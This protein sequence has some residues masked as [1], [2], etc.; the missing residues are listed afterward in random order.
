MDADAHADWVAGFDA[1]FARVAARFGRVEPRR[2]ARTYLLGLL[3]PVQRK[4][5]W[6]L[7]EAAGEGRPDGMQRLLN[8]ARWDAGGVRDDLRAYV[9]EHLGHPDGVLVVDEA[10]F[11][12]KGTS[13][14]G[15]EPQT[16]RGAE[17]A[18]NCQVG[19]FLAYETPVGQALIDR[20]LYLPRSWVSDPHR[21][22]AAGVPSWI[23]YAARPVQAAAMLSR[24][25]DA[26]VPARWVVAGEPYGADATFREFLERRGAGYVVTVSRH[27][28]V[29]LPSGTARV[30]DLVPTAP[31]QAWKRVATSA[32]P[33][34]PQPFE[35]AVCD[36]PAAG[37]QG[38]SLLVRRVAGEP[39]TLAF[40]L[41]A[42]PRD[43]GVDTL[44]RIADAAP[45]VRDCLRRAR[46]EVGLGRHQVRRYE[47]WY[48]HVTLALLAHAYVAVRTVQRLRVHRPI[49]H[50]QRVADVLWRT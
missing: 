47:A 26:G 40:F 3:G 8:G 25:F 46:A 19:V 2:R 10:G 4:T 32:G 13:S 45:T 18:Q 15:V 34:R 17:R 36:L 43:T 49:A 28:T 30:A 31:E 37:A 33:D 50:A 16:W 14:A 39:Q 38:R 27:Q 29:T 20:E 12:R 9:V 7:A 42:G 22:A 24:A 48:R 44:A 1:M 35:W 5:G 23:R 11:V 41:C 6:Q 21:C